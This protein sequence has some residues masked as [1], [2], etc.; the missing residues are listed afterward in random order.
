MPTRKALA[1][2]REIKAMPE[3]IA[4]HLVSG[5]ADYHLEVVVP[6]L[7]HY[8]SWSESYWRCRLFATY[9]ATSQ[10]RL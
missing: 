8:G 2:E 1:F 7:E 6:D 4:C 3:V 10:F 9:A 5:E